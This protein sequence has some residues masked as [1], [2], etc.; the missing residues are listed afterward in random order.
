MERKDIPRDRQSEKAR[1]QKPKVD[2]NNNNNGHLM[3]VQLYLFL[4]PKVLNSFLYS[5]NCSLFG[6]R[7]YLIYFFFCKLGDRRRASNNT[8]TYIIMYSGKMDIN[9]PGF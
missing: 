9:H 6:V 5:Q 4:V 1:K 7:R 3:E 2:N 8:N